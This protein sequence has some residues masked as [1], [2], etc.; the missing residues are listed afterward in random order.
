MNG[1]TM[2]RELIVA[3]YEN[4]FASAVCNCRAKKITFHQNRTVRQG[5]QRDQFIQEFSMK[6]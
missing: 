2:S 1:S 6:E 4:H 5:V 3:E